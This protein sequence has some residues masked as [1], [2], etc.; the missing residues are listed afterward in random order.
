MS[1]DDESLG[2]TIA[3]KFFALLII[4]IG[5]ILLYNTLSSSNL[6]F[7]LI[8]TVSGLALVLLGVFMIL[9]KAR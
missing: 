5:G 2:Y 4:T 3:E 9:A 6:A 8:F 7:P 1:T